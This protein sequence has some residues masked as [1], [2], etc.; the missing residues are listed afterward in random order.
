MIW[1][2]EN[3]ISLGPC[4]ADRLSMPTELEAVSRRRY[5]PHYSLSM[6]FNRR[7]DYSIGDLSSHVFLGNVCTDLNTDLDSSD[8]HSRV[9]YSW[10][11]CVFWIPRASILVREIP[12]KHLL[13]VT[14]INL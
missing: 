4:L 12:Q 14:T 6:A 1:G 7:G 10:C 5:S 8:N 9:W 3:G 13:P 2:G 11:Q